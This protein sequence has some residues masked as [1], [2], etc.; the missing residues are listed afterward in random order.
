MQLCIADIRETGDGLNHL[1]TILSTLPH[2]VIV[3]MRYLFA[4]LNQYVHRFIVVQCS[5]NSVINLEILP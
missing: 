4:F 2:A 1:Q 3:V 5:T